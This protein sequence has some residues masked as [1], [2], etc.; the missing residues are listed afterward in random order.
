[1]ELPPNDLI[2]D[3]IVSWETATAA[4]AGVQFA[5]VLLMKI[6]PT[7]WKSWSEPL[8]KNIPVTIETAPAAQA[9]VQFPE[10]FA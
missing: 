9:G 2:N 1:M 6:H 8:T 5:Q 3:T 4:E 10:L 7:Y